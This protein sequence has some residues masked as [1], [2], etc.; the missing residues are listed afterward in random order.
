MRIVAGRARLSASD[1]ANHLGC[2]YLTALDLAAAE[3]RIPL[4]AWRDPALAVLQARGLEFEQG[5]LDHLAAAGVTITRLDPDAEDS[6][7]AAFDRTAQAMRRGDDVIVQATLVH[8]RWLGRADVLRRVARPSALGAWSYEVTDTK[9]ARETRG[10]T[11]LQLC[12]YSD[13]VGSVQG[14]LPEAMHVVAPGR[15]F[16]PESHRTLDFMAYY[17]FVCARLESAVDAAGVPGGPAGDLLDAAPDGLYPEPVEMCDMCRWWQGCDRRR[18]SDDHLSFVAG[19]SRAQR[20][21]LG[22]WGVPTMADLAGMPLPLERKPSRGSRVSMTRV[23]EQARVQ[24]E[25]RTSGEPVFELL[26][27]EPGLGFARLPEPSPGDVFLD[28]E[29]DAFVG[30]TGI[31]YLIGWAGRDGAEVGYRAD[32]ALEP[33]RE[34]AAFE[35]FVDTVMARWDRDPG[36]HVYH[37][38]TYEPAALKRLMGRFASREAEI[39]AMLR[40]G[41]FVDLHAI[42]R[43]ALRASVEQ[44]SIKD[45]EPFYSYVR[46]AALEDVRPVLRTVEHALELGRPDRI[47][48]AARAV[49]QAY[50]RDDCISALALRDWLES[51]RAQLVRDG[52]TIE[53]PVADAPAP[54]EEVKEREARIAPLRARL[55]DGVPDDPAACDPEQGARRLLAYLLDWHRREGKVKWWEFF[56]LCELPEDELLDEVRAVAGLEFVERV[57]TPKRSVVDRYR[58]PAQEVQLR[59]GMDLVLPGKGDR[60]GVIEAVHAADG[61]IDVRKGPSRADVHPRSA[62]ENRSYKPKAQEDA[63]ER[64]AARVLACGVDGEG[65]DRA[66]RDLLLRRPPRL[67]PAAP[68]GAPLARPGESGL[69][70]A[71]RLVSALDRGV[72]AIQGPPGSGKTFTGARMILA[73]VRAGKKIGVTSNSHKAFR[74]LLDAVVE[75][76]AEAGEEVACVHKI[77]DEESLGDPRVVEM[78]E[79]EDVARALADGSAHVAGGTAFMWAREDFADAVDVLFVDEAG[80]MSLANVVAVSQAAGSLV[81][82]GDPRQLDQPKQGSHPE[83]VGVSAL[84]HLLGERLTI[85]PDQGLFLDRTWRLPPAI[86]RFTSELFYE[87]RLES[88]PVT[89]GQA[90]AGGPVEGSGLWFLPA[91][92]DG[93]RNSNPIEAGVVADLIERVLAAGTQWMDGRGVARPLTLDDVLIVAPYNAQVA[94]IQARIPGARVGTVDLF[95]GREAPLVIYSMTTSSPAEAPRGMD[96]LYALDRLNVATSRAQGACVLVASPALLEPDCRTPKQMRLANAFCRYREMARLLEPGTAEQAV[97]SGRAQSV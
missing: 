62:F 47:D 59:E 15:G 17:R 75:A 71:L 24:V 86:T 52:E 42:V 79:N 81:L 82:L 20:V 41:V 29:G 48:A 16:A 6:P 88:S 43:Q 7:A 44:Y 30:T 54:P 74:N 97:G 25:G 87:N 21:D 85:A 69:E 2:R 46:D 66:A 77:G 13:I 23:R 19:I 51:L 65:P 39:D 93:H 83:G 90:L 5:F 70:A 3:G 14:L 56:R 96:F 80:Q 33:A 58:F 27:R 31:E 50:N 92:H 63:L 35:A 40:G 38:A 55:L 45:L 49:V 11:M 34:R 10:S 4:P 67:S 72:L 61:R 64:L 8:G 95:Q 68:H 89:A 36:M 22:E 73:L 91:L 53:R 18:R 9:L 28:L 78:E 32:W 1:L 84:D 12:L 60:W 26:P 37:F 76:A 57:A 94:E